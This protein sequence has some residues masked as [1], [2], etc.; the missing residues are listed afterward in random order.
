MRH[1][2]ASAARLAALCALVLTGCGGGGGGDAGPGPSDAPAA[3]GPREARLYVGYYAEDPA[4]NPED[5]TIGVVMFRVPGDDGPFAGQ[6][7][8]SYVGCRA[9]TDTGT[10][11]GTRSGRRIEGRWTG[12]MDERVTVGG[13]L[14]ATYDAAADAFVGRFTNA[15][16]KVPVIDGPCR[17]AI[18]AGGSLQVWGDAAR[19]PAGVS[20]AASGGVTPTFTWTGLPAGSLATVR[21]FDWACVQA[22]PGNAA[23]FVGESVPT[24]AG[25][26]GFPATFPSASALRPG[27]EYLVIVTGQAP[28]TGAFAGYGSLRFTASPTATDGAGGSGGGGGAAAPGLG[29]LVIAGASMGDGFEPGASPDGTVSTN[30]TGPTCNAGTGLCT[31]ALQITWTEQDVLGGRNRAVSVFLFS[32][33]SVAPGPAP[34][35]AVTQVT[36]VYSQLLP[37]AQRATY[38]EQCG[39]PAAIL[40]RCPAVPLLGVRWTPGARTVV[41]DD[42]ALPGQSPTTG[43]V[44]LQGTL[45]Y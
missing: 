34:G 5:P 11:A 14:E 20:L 38:V 21:V 9:G 2:F 42:V 18:A 45:R 36:A 1:A 43:Q 6:M 10:I 31:S 28:A 12:I 24:T 17:Y 25:A 41:F 29:R 35:E 32:T 16:G 27:A 13:S 26:T 40:P 8:F 3:G 22:D 19:Q 4:D 33:S 23:C 37:A 15:Q 30:S 44:R 7:P 39:E